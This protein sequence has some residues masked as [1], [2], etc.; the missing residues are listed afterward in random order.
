MARH[1]FSGYFDRFLRYFVDKEISNHIGPNRS[2][3]SLDAEKAFTDA[4]KVYT[5]QSSK[6]IEEYAG[7]W[8][9][10]HNWEFEGDITPEDARRINSYGLEKFRMEL[11]REEGQ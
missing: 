3:N 4:L 1:F 7:G 10:K 2:L 6:I 11:S 8:Y 5:W 9:S